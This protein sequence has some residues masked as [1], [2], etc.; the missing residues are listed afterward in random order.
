[1]KAA[2]RVLLVGAAGRMGKTI[3]D[4]AKSDPNIQIVAQCDLGDAIE[5]AMKDCDVVIDFSFHDATA[6]AAS[7]EIV[8]DNFSD[9]KARQANGISRKLGAT[10]TA[11]H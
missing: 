2:L 6:E 9:E 1:M 8:D 3:V 10:K 4:L 5:P 7:G 11:N